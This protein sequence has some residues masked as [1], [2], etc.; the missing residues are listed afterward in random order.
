MIDLITFLYAYNNN[1]CPISAESMLTN[2][3]IICQL[4]KI[5]GE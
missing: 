5:I 4:E 3:R 2:L 1:P